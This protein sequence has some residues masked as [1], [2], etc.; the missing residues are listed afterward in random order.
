MFISGWI[1]TA[2]AVLHGLRLVFGWSAVIGS[3][4]F[5]PWLSVIGLL[6]AGYLAFVAFR[7]A[8]RKV[9]N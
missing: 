2:V 8:F 3:W 4:S 9:D 5:P 6:V 7:L 1:F